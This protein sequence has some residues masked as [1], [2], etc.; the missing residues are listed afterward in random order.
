MQHYI[1]Y[2]LLHGLLYTTPIEC[3]LL[4]ALSLVKSVMYGFR[5]TLAT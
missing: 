1:W 2:R 3:L 5:S 4:G